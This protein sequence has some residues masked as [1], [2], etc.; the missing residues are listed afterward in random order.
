[1]DNTQLAN[2]CNKLIDELINQVSS[3]S[4]EALNRIQAKTD[5]Y[6][7]AKSCTRFERTD[8]NSKIFEIIDTIVDGTEKA[9]TLNPINLMGTKLGFYENYLDSKHCG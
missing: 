3:A 7:L 1:M 4:D 8:E 9:N 6:N 5:N 2:K